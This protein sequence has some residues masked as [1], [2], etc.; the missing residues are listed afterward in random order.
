MP[1]REHAMVLREVR[2]ELPWP[3]SVSGWKLLHIIK[4][5]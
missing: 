5:S 1:G 2:W 4:T 3:Y